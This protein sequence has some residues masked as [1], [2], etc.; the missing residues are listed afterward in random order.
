MDF[1]KR[2]LQQFLVLAEEQHF[3]RAAER[4]SMSQPPLSQ[5]IKRLEGGLGVTLLERGPGGV[6]LTPAGAAFAAEAQRMLDVRSAAIE[7]VQRVAHG[8]EGDV[9]VGYV[10]ILSYR[11]LP[12]LL[13]AAARELPGLR[14]RLH[15]ESSVTLAEM[16]RS[17][18]L[19]LA[20]IRDPSPV[21]E[22]LAVHDFVV[23]RIVAALPHEHRL[24]GAGSIDLADLRDDDFVLPGATALPALAQQAQLACRASGF[25]PRGRAEADDLT[26]LLSYVSAGLC[27]SL[28]PQDLREFPIPGIAFVPLR[29]ASPYLETTVAAVHRPGADAAVRRLLDLCLRH[30][31]AG[32]PRGA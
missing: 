1:T 8:L 5:T 11:H 27:V 25:T 12:G 31:R 26:G 2:L 24:A 32:V 13:R 29:G 22:E 10:S 23:E 16:I 28:L 15:Q 30:T 18:T 6:R 19:D 20:F 21:S 4:L 9:R 7:R 17:G 3:G 14:I